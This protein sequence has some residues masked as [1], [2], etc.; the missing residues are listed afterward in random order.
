MDATQVIADL[1]AQIDWYG[2]L[3]RLAELQHTLVEQE[4]TDDLLVV[5]EKRQRIVEAVTA[6]EA[7]LRPVKLGWHD[8]APSLAAPERAQIEERFTQVRALLEQITRADQDDA[9]LL[10]QRKINV[11]QQLRRTG[12]AQQVNRGYAAAN[13]YGSA[14]GGRMDVSR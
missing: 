10:Q 9:L 3:L 7:R 5:L 2:K 4:R 1:S 6:I 12:S 13:A 8:Q 11:G 14:V